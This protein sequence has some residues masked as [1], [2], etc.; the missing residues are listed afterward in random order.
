MPEPSSGPV[1]KT[2]GRKCPCFPTAWVFLR[3]TQTALPATSQLAF[4]WVVQ[5]AGTQ[6]QA[7]A[8]YRI[9]FSRSRQKRG[10]PTLLF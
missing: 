6:A 2:W 3:D 4:A 10:P 5:R 8:G 7:E 1:A 9:S